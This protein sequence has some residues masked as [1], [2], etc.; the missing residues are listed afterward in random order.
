MNAQEYNL[1]IRPGYGYSQTVKVSQDDIGRPLEFHLYDGMDMLAITTGTVITIHATKPSGLGFTETCTWSGSTAS[2]STTESM[3]Q[4]SGAF[5]AELVI[6]SGD[7]VLGTANFTFCVERSPHQTG[8]TDGVAEDLQDIYEQLDD[9]KEDIENIS[10]ISDDVKTALLAIAQNV[11]YKNADADYYQNLYDALYPPAQTYTVTNTLTGCTTSN[12]AIAVTENAPYSATI[13]ASSGYSLTGATVSITMG[14]TD[15]TATAYNNG[16]ISIASVTGNLIITVTAVAVTLS[17][18]SAVYTQSGTVY[19]TDSLDSLKADLVVTATW[20][21]SST[22]TV[23]SADYTLS[24]TLTAGTSTVTVSY[25]GKTTTFSVT[26]TQEIL[27]S[28]PSSMTFN[29]SSDYVD[30]G[31][32]LLENDID[33]T[34]A[35]TETNGTI[36][37][38]NTLFHCMTEDLPY[39]GMSMMRTSTSG[40]YDIGGLKPNGTKTACKY[41]NGTTN[42]CVFRHTAGTNIYTLSSKTGST[43]NSVLTVEAQDGY[44][45]TAKNLLIGCYQQTDGTKGRYWTGTVSD[46]TIYNR[47][48]TDDEVT[49]YLGGS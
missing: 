26:V 34:I 6:T 27:Y 28:L 31:V 30:T 4:E 13:T 25:G 37:Q 2:I 35:F 41:A 20:S 17:S 3:T 5:P 9:L 14:G 36:A 7:D 8:T 1:N 49:A 19:D 12:T 48:L 45:T 32:K 40:K 39:P 43:L 11:V 42:K 10:G 29:G 44:V 15:I 38:Q 16:A 18:I 24:G 23:D 22:T 46:F 47:V 21:D 33:F